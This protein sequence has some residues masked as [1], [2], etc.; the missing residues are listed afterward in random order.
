M[1][2]A[3]NLLLIVFTTFLVNNKVHSQITMPVVH[4]LEQ[5]VCNAF[6][7]CSDT[8]FN[9]KSYMGVGVLWE[10]LPG[11]NPF[12]PPTPVPGG[13]PSGNNEDSLRENSHW[14]KLKIAESGFLAF[15][16]IPLNNVDFYQILVFKANGTCEQLYTYSLVRFA[17]NKNDLHYAP[18]YTHTGIKLDSSEST[19]NKAA[20]LF[21]NAGEEYYIR[22]LAASKYVYINPLLTIASP[23]KAGYILDLSKKTCKFEIGPPPLVAEILGDGCGN[24]DYIDLLL[25]R[26][27]DCSSI[28]INGSDFSIS[29]AGTITGA[30][31]VGC[32]F[33]EGM[34]NKIKLFYDGSIAPGFYSINVQE[35]TDGN[36]LLDICYQESPSPQSLTFEVQKLKDTVSIYICTGALPHN[37]NGISMTDTGSMLASFKTENGRGCDSTTYLNLYTVDSFVHFETMYV[38]EEILPIV[39]YD[40]QST[41]EYGDRVLRKVFVAQGGCDSI[42][43]LNLYPQDINRV[44]S[45][46]V[47]CEKFEINEEVF[48]SSGFYIDTLY[49]DNGCITSIINYDIDVYSPI[50]V[51]TIHVDTGACGHMYIGD[52]LMYKD[53]VFVDTLTTWFGC[54][55]V[56]IQYNVDITPNIEP[57]VHRYFVQVCDSFTI[58]ELMVS[59]DT[60]LT[61]MYK[62]QYNCDSVVTVYYVTIDTLDLDVVSFPQK[63]VKGEVI[64]LHVAS[65]QP[66]VKVHYWSPTELFPEQTVTEQTL[67]IYEPLT[68]VVSA[69]DH[70]GCKA[71][72]TLIISEI[73][74]LIKFEAIPNAF[75]PNGDGLND[76]FKIELPNERGREIVAMH[77]YDRW[78]KVVFSDYG[79]N[80]FQWNGQ[81]GNTDQAAPNGVY[82]FQMHIRYIDGEE[83]IVTGDITLLR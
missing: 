7:L 69:E 31:G 44:D 5:D 15:D 42:I 43:Y 20:P 9:Y 80:H 78:G 56:Y 49:S 79:N 72:D 73:D 77:I 75:S 55:S 61:F 68:V 33:G 58:N 23:S 12:A 40:G 50:L 16:L 17:S 52:R 51:E 59:S 25:N 46:V 74:S 65:T 57:E 4:Q 62:N 41:F 13:P 26:N 11:S 18:T 30:L 64:K 71:I 1:K 48:E 3:L 66:N 76:I 81:Y 38:C 35:G 21:V 6:T 83:K 45:H 82:Y 53:S 63:P 24:S 19:D 47:A 36:T 22:V 27:V 37:W 39:W 60:M 14:L 34:T 10:S 29:P 67:R 32:S 2:N 70:R 8:F 28:E 54:D